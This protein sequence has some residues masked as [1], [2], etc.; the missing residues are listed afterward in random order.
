M[1]SVG[2]TLDDNGDPNW[3]H[4]SPSLWT[5]YTHY[6]V[7]GRV[8]WTQNAGGQETYYEYDAA[9]KQTKVTV[10]NDDGEDTITEYR[11]E[12][13][14]RVW[15]QDA[16]SN[17]TQ[18]VYDDLGRLTDTYYPATAQNGQTSTHA[19]YDELGRRTAQTDQAGRTRWFD[20]DPAGRLI[21]VILPDVN[22]PNNSDTP[23]YPRYE[24]KYDTYGNLTAIWD[25][26]KED[27]N[28]GHH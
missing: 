6:D 9:G 17:I 21:A 20:Y 5:T 12:G 26:V 14:Q 23:T 1:L 4:G 2:Q 24:Y 22:D 13:N 8:Q 3:S 16:R 25:N 15:V 28:S 10:V 7:A 27:P 11:Y 19:E 18:F